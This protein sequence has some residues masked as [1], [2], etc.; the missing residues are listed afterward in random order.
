MQQIF[1]GLATL[2]DG[3]FFERLSGD[4][5]WRIIGTTKWSRTY[6]G[7]EEILRDMFETMRT[8]LADRIKLRLR[9]GTIADGE[10]VA[11]EAQ[12]DSVTKAGLHRNEYC[13]VFRIADGQI[14]EVTGIL[15]RNS[16]QRC[17]AA[18]SAAGQ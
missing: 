5:R 7:K 1:A 10:L 2:G 15:R 18:T 13:M 3:L 11:V 14:A 16:S 17:S 8:V 12:G 9:S 6:E 4:A